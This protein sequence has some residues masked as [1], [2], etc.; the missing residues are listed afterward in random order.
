MTDLERS[1]TALGGELDWP[2]TPALALSL[3]PRR[4]Q[5][6]RPLVLALAA[7]VAAIAVAFAVPSARSA[8]LRFLHLGGVRID[9]VETLPA[10]Q[11][12]PLAAALGT[13]IPADE[14]RAILGRAF[15]LPAT[16][17]G[18][19]LYQQDGVVSALL[20]TP[21][22]VLLSEFPDDGILMQKIA[23]STTGIQT[24]AIRPG[25]DGLWLSGAGHVVVL[26]GVP[27]RLAGN[28]LIWTSGGLTYRLEGRSLDEQRAIAIAR[29]LAGT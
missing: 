7:A 3:E 21:A 27:P 16:A 13:Q 15:R 25:L 11:Q 9:R 4:R 19:R 24:V 23:S 8:I 12:V 14:A 5:R 29:E 20:A 2:A 10:A 28:V 1:L 26:A 17:S 6:P 18:A 22:P